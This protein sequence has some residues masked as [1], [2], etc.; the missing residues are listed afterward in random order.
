[1]KTDYK[2]EIELYPTDTSNKEEPYFWSLMSSSG[3][4]WHTSMAG[5]A[6]T[7]EEAFEKVYGYY[8]TMREDNLC[9]S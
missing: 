8:K 5:Y 9:I 3:N 6:A 4:G 2:I 1:M 7:P